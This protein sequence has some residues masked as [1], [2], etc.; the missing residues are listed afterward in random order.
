MGQEDK[1]GSGR[2]RESSGGSGRVQEDPGGC[3]MVGRV[4]EALVGHF[5]SGRV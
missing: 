5:E 4:E 3:G 1:G 2:V